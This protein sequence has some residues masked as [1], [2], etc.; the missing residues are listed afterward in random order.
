MFCLGKAGKTRR[1][2]PD[3]FALCVK[4][5]SHPAYSF[6]KCTYSAG[7]AELVDAPDLGSGAVRRGGSSPSTRTTTS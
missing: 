3:F 5:L 6:V 7:V 2:H 4:T 1:I